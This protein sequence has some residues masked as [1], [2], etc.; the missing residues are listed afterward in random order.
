MKLH[1]NLD[2]SVTVIIKRKGEVIFE[3]QFKTEKHYKDFFELVSNK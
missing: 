3:H 2:G 1:Y